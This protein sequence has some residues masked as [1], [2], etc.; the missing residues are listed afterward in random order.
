VVQL[1]RPS[2]SI[3]SIIR[4]S[5]TAETNPRCAVFAVLIEHPAL[6]V[7]SSRPVRTA[8]PLLDGTSPLA[9]IRT[10]RARTGRWPLARRYPASPRA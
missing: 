6:W 8:V 1:R 9:H 3:Q 4:W 10:W 5:I 2:P 7:L